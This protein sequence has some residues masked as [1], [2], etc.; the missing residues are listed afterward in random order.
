MKLHTDL[1]IDATIMVIMTLIAIA[2]LTGD[3]KGMGIHINGLAKIVD[4]RGGVRSLDT[5]TNLQ[6]KVCR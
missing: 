4:L 6:V 1:S 3:F 5:F 2:E